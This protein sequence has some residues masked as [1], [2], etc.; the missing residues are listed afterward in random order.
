MPKRLDIKK[1]MIIGAGP[2]VIGQACEFDY[3]GAQACK[4]LKEEGYK[5]ILVNSNPATIMTD[6]NLAHKTYIEPL[7]IF[8]LE[9]IISKERP[10]A[11]LS[12]MGGQTALNLS[13]E[14]KEKGILS[15][16][17]V[18]LIGATQ[19]V[20]EKA[21]NRELFKN[22]MSKIGLDSP[23][24]FVVNNLS[25][26]I[27]ISKSLSFP[28]IVRP[29][30]TLG[31]S[32]GGTAKNED[33]F[34]KI[35][36]RGINLSPINEVLVEESLEGWKEYEM[37][38]IRDKEDNCIIICSIENVD[39]MGI[40][41]GD[42][43]TV[44]PSLTLSDK[45][46]QKMRNQSIQVIREIGVETGGANVQ[47]A[48]NPKNGRMVVIEMNPRVS[49]SSALASK[50]TG[51]PIARIA[52]KL[53]IGFTLDELKN[54]ITKTTPAAFE[55]TIDYIV[56]KIPR[57]TFEKFS[58]TEEKLGT[59]M[60]S[61]GECMA[62]GRSFKESFQKAIRSLEIGLDGLDQNTNWTKKNK[63][64]LLKLVGQNI[65]NKF[66]IIAEC[67]RKGIPLKQIS[68]KSGYDNWFL[69]EISELIDTE[70]QLK[71]KMDLDN[72]VRAKK[73]GFSDSKIS[74]LSKISKKK[75]NI[76][77]KN[78]K[79]KTSFKN[80]DTCSGE[81]ESFTPYMYSS[82][83]NNQIKQS[84]EKETKVTPKKKV[85]IIGGGPNRIGQG[86][87]FDYCCVHSSFAVKEMDIES[88]MINCNPE[89]V[90]TDFDISDRL[91]FEPLDFESVLEICMA[92]NRFGNLAGVIVQLGGQTPLKL[93]ERINKEK[94]KILGTS[95]KSIDLCE[96]RDSFNKIVR[97]LNIHQPKS[98]IVYNI[99]EAERSIKNIE[100]PVVIRP[101]YVLG[102]RAMRIINNKSEL[103]NYFESNFIKNGKSIL[104]D[105]FLVGAKEI[106]VDAI[107]DGET[108]FIAGI[109]EHIEEAGVHSGDSACSIPTQTISKIIL[110]EI[111]RLT[112]KIS[113][114]LNI[115]GFIN[116]QFAIKDEKIFVL[117]VNPRAS[118]TV[119]F[120]SKAIG[121]PLANVATKIMLGKKL[122]EFK[123]NSKS[124]SFVFVKESVFPFDRFP[125]EDVILG[126]E[127]KS[128][129][130]V[131]GVDKNFPL[132][133]LKSQIASGNNLPLKGSVF[134]SVRDEDKENILLLSQVLKKLD[135]K[136]IATKGT[137]NFLE[138]FGIKSKVAKKVADGSP[139]VV[140]LIE[141][142]KI[143]LVINTTSGVKSIA[144][145]FSIR[146][147]AIRNKIPYFTTISAAKIAV[148]GLN[149][150]K[151]KDFSINSLQ[152]MYKL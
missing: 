120:I 128:T 149:L 94:I 5:V 85:I 96:D 54:D 10:D 21:E 9:K 150:V 14:L 44:A 90:S 46:F 33:E 111:K 70:N 126:P 58:D 56:T 103:K 105:Q 3:S 75:C 39:P 23:K 4:A 32:G 40:H 25:K 137:A 114:K 45:E 134:I 145:S 1:I 59:A 125:G 148:T 34:V 6:P 53:A 143:Q 11:L 108:I 13:I 91:Y 17:N 93:A 55:P 74:E 69:R 77:K 47:F 135:F 141:K 99:G 51:F 41:T 129:G 78:N 79:L 127:M 24:G 30:F 66:L 116:I 117:E 97:Q 147:S 121:I 123:L 95:Y 49:R 133:Y 115:I 113:I 89:T 28:I 18:E 132:A 7:S 88:I 144:D 84:H 73:E 152:E 19:S 60:K 119:P 76:F 20:I 83:P 104:I 31:G 112:K 140:D 92:E 16:Y 26:A 67:L 35:I 52:A 100:F 62:I 22:S 37:E 107:S 38:V 102:G 130:E 36:K 109:L 8:F 15:K 118:R 98:D 131:M 71:K 81:F 50:A 87:E 68:K 80:I 57:F 124:K 61:I 146:R 142:K 136:I 29:S 151:N 106:D 64:T 43:I 122:S 27:K 42:S 63:E 65:P 86:I 139:H 2:I 48:V 101:S 138:K 12:T 82:W 72:Y 110:D